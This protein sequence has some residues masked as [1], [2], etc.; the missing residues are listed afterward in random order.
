MT[1]KTTETEADVMAFIDAVENPTR[2]ADAMVV[3][4]MLVFCVFLHLF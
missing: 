2:R 1:K 4:E 3:L